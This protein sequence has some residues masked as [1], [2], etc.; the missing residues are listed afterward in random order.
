MTDYIGGEP[1]HLELYKRHIRGNDH[2]N[3][4]TPPYPNL[5]RCGGLVHQEW[6]PTH[7]ST[8][9]MACDRCGNAILNKGDE[10]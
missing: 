3:V 5:C 1:N 4:C 7:K 6:H 8:L 9:K 10:Q 2:C